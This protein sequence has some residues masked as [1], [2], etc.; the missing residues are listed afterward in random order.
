VF[1]AGC[2][3]H[4]LYCQNWGISRS[5]QGDEVE[6]HELADIFLELQT[7]GCHNLNLVSPT[8]VIAPIL[9][10]LALA[11]PR[12]FQL[13]VVYNTGGYD[14]PEALAL[15][16]GVVD[17]YMPDMKYSDP[18]TG[19]RLSHAEHYPRING[20]AVR[21]MHRQVG[22]LVLDGDGIAR[23]GLL[24]R[25]LVLPGGLAGTEEVLR[26]V[27]EEISRNTYLNLM[28]QY[29]PCAEAH[30]HPPLD[31]RL[32]PQEYHAAVEFAHRHGLRRLD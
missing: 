12:G 29:R 2:N 30:R 32:R 18:A 3:L 21:E 24:V 22:D 14:S 17:I 5:C 10:A 26:F 28:D 7:A 20:V 13:P 11:L 25:H 8:H 19:A 23:R 16:D 31:R 4:C 15:L 9:A 6:A 1:F 27:A